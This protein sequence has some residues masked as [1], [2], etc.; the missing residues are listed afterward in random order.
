MA[1]QVNRALVKSQE[2]KFKPTKES[3]RREVGETS[4]KTRIA[5]SMQKHHSRGFGRTSTNKLYRSHQSDSRGIIHIYKNQN[6]LVE[7]VRGTSLDP[8]DNDKEEI[9]PAAD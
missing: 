9:A 4:S 1:E 7:K 5:E 2:F 8:V 3:S 6:E